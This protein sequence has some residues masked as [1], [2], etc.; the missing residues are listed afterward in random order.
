MQTESLSLIDYL[1]ASAGRFPERTAVVDPDGTG[2]SYREL[3]ARADRIGAFLSAQGLGRGDRVALLMPKSSATLIA[4]LG[5]MKAGAAYVPIDWTAPANRVQTIIADC[6]TRAVFVD[7]RVTAKLGDAASA[8]QNVIVTGPSNENHDAAG[9]VTWD[10]VLQTEFPSAPRLERSRDDLA[11]ILYTSGSTGVPKGVMLSHG[12]ALSFVDWCSSVFHPTEDDRFSSHAPFHFDLSILDIYVPL[13]HGASVH[14]IDDETG[15]NPKELAKFI[16]ERQL[17]VWYSTPSILH[18]LASLGNLPR[19]D[20]PNLRLVLFAGEVFPVKH[21]RQ[22]ADHW[23]HPHYYNLYGPTETNVCTYAPVP[24]QIPDD[25]T[26]PYPIGP[27]CAHCAAAVLDSDGKTVAPG[28]EGVL[29]I[30]GESV[31]R[32]YWNRPKETAAAFLLRDG[33]RWYSTGDV[34]RKDPEHGFI[35]V[36]RRDRMV[37]RRGYRIELDD[38]ECALYRH[39]HIREAAVIAAAPGGAEV[40]IAA[41]LAAAP[42]SEPDIVQMKIFCASQLQSYMNPDVFVFLDKLPRTST[43]KVDYQSLTRQFQQDFAETFCKA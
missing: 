7:A 8:L 40:K 29:Y 43:N 36:G 38:I 16:A 37:K 9:V 32:G 3:N 30:S 13:K 2:I 33:R 21:L 25:R 28:N 31:F 5:I 10:E 22:L 41:Y 17:T 35:Y 14:L 39:Q 18:L 23:P 34:V 15:K 24:S 20:Y 11:Y 19:Y 26:E 1:E 6:Q 12:N 4:I 27:A 42:D